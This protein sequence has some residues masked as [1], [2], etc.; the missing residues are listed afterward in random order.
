VIHDLGLD[1]RAVTVEGVGRQFALLELFEQ[2]E[3]EA[4]AE[5]ALWSPR[6]TASR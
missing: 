6:P 2:A 1:Q 4:V 3:A 5:I